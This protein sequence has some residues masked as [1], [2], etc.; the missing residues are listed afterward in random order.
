MA[1]YTVEELFY[2]DKYGI[3]GEVLKQ[4]FARQKEFVADPHTFREI[5]LV[6]QTL[7][8]VEKMKQNGDCIAEC[9]L[10]DAVAIAISGGKDDEHN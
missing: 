9:E 10:G 6:R 1:K 5:E 2:G 8:A 7:I 4:M 3:M